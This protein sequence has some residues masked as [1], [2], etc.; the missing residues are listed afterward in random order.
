MS[1]KI[2]QSTIYIAVSI[3]AVI[4]IVVALI[5]T[6]IQNN[7]QS[8]TATTEQQPAGNNDSGDASNT[9]AYQTIDNDSNV[10]QSEISD[11]DGIVQNVPDS[12]I[13][14]INRMFGYTLDLNGINNKI[15]DAVVRDGTYSQS[16]IDT[17]R[18]IYQTTFM[19]DIPSLQQSYYVKDLYSPLPVEQSGLYDYTVQITCPTSSQLIYQPFDCVDR[20]S[21]EQT[22]VRE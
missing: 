8:N 12:E 17:D 14:S 19:I 21:Y 4:I 15:N 2:K 7:Q 5:L 18:L 20:I 10:E 22:G 9:I 1:G 13:S 11:L 3:M 6:N 16:L